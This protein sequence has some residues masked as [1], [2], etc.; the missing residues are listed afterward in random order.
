[1]ANKYY[2]GDLHLGHENMA[3]KRGFENALSMFKYMKSKWNKKIRKNDIVYILGD[4]SMETRKHYH[5]L[6]ELN[7]KKIAILGNHDRRQDAK[8]LLN[9]C[10]S[11]AGMVKYKNIFFTHCPIHPMELD[12]RVEYN[13]HAHCHEKSVRKKFIGIKLWKDKRYICVSCEQ[14]D[15]TPMALQELNFKTIR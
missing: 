13:V 9:H 2:I 7:G 12:Y 15:Y 4:I 11:V 10:I 1:M 8:V 14:V 5:L 3:V 6:D